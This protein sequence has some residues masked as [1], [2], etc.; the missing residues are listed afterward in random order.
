MASKDNTIWANPPKLQT[1]YNLFE[2]IQL[3]IPNGDKAP[4]PNRFGRNFF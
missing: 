4:V 1:L 3:P 2:R